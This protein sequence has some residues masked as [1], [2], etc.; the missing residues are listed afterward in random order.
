MSL[1]PDIG[2][3]AYLPHITGNHSLL[4]EL[5]YTARPFS[6]SVAFSQLGL[7]SKVVDGGREQVVKEALALAETVAEKSPVAIV[8][9]KALITHSRDHR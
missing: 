2:T 1:A 7:I 8:A 3:L 4:R 5:T 6:A 9:S